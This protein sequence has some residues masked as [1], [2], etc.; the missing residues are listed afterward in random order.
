MKNNNALD[1]FYTCIYIYI[2][3][4]SVRM[5]TEPFP[6]MME[7]KKWICPTLTF[8]KVDFHK[9]DL[10]STQKDV[11]VAMER[12]TGFFRVRLWPYCRLGVAE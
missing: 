9:S 6:N 8:E 12:T 1:V 2:H 11:C 10:T 3:I 5:V 7:G 4:Y